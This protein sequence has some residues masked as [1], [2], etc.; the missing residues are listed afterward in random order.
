MT[1]WN[2]T[3]YLRYG[4][5]RIR[6]ALDL[7]GRINLDSA[8]IIYDLGCGTGTI[9][10]ILKERWSQAAVTGVDSSPNMLERTQ[11]VQSGV[12]W[13]HADLNKWVP[14][15]PA[16]LIYSNAAFHWLD[17]HDALFPRLMSFL[18]DG[19]VLAVQMPE[20][21]NAPSH[22]NIAATARE[23]K[24]AER[25]VP[26][27]MENPVADPNFYYDMLSPLSTSLDMWESI[28]MHILN[29]DDPVVE[30]TKGTVLPPLLSH[31]P[32]EEH[33][34]FISSYG[35]KV[36]KAYPKRSDGKT[37]LPFRRLFMVAAK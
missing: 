23:S 33:E 29:G 6:P 21:W 8:E 36:S 32:E 14:S 16:D 25:L 2:P 30:W 26:H 27:L 19:G 13:E 18:K 37:I 5:E 34:E 7:M 22:S 9:T 31:L 24:W 10:G 17:G 3:Q 28:Y 15:E 1:D 20:N 11:D 4:N 12:M 35:M